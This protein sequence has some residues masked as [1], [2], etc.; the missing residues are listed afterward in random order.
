MRPNRLTLSLLG[1]LL[2]VLSAPA[3]A[4]ASSDWSGFYI[5]GNIGASD[6]L[7]SGGDRILFDSNLDGSFGDAIRTTAGVDAFTPGSCGGAALERTPAGGCNGDKGGADYGLRAG[8]DWQVDRWVFGVVGEYTQGDAR[9]S[10]TA[11]SITPAFYTFTR[12]LES[13]TALRARVGM[14]FGATGDWLAYAT[15]GAVRARIDQRFTTSNTANSFTPTTGRTNANG[16]QAGL[17]VERKV[18]DHL[19]LGIEYLYTSVKDDEFGVRVARGAAPA[20]SPFLTA[21]PNGTDF[22]RSEED[23]KFGSLRLTATYRF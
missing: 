21:N 13:T 12:D 5:G 7:D 17:G 23:F 4:Q 11:F 18:L 6:T 15:A 22:R 14:A 19:S 9:D 20:T 10:T 3:A 8:Y 16:F 2:A 1:S